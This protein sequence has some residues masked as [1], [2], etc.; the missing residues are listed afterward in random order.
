MEGVEGVE[1]GQ[2]GGQS[3]TL[4]II[5]GVQPGAVAPAGQRGD[6]LHRTVLLRFQCF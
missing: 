2:E 5:H 3:L 4:D 6:F 1:G